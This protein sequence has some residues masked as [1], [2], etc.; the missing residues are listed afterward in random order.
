M[1]KKGLEN[2]L[3]HQI[4][5][6]FQNND[7]HFQEQLQSSIVQEKGTSIVPTKEHLIW[8][9]KLF[10][11]VFMLLLFTSI[12]IFMKSFTFFLLQKRRLHTHKLFYLVCCCL[13]MMSLTKTL[14]SFSPSP[15]ISYRNK[16]SKINEMERELLIRGCFI[17]SHLNSL[18][19]ES[20]GQNHIQCISVTVSWMTVLVILCDEAAAPL[21]LYALGHKGCAV[22]VI[23]S[24]WVFQL[25][26]SFTKLNKVPKSR[27]IKLI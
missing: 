9:R 6:T 19:F 4:M 14:A 18:I 2:S 8:P 13:I 27:E 16:S 11:T 20:P 1:D 3:L 23:I 21:T 26:S 24:S 15:M 22:L 17:S 12:P 7:G 10:L 25:D 5:T